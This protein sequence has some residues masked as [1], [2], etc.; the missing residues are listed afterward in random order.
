MYEEYLEDYVYR[1]MAKVASK[2]CRMFV[3]KKTNKANETQALVVKDSTNQSDVKAIENKKDKPNETDKTDSIRKDTEINENINKNEG[4]VAK[5]DA[6]TETEDTVPSDI[7]KSEVTDSENCDTKKQGDDIDEQLN[8]LNFH[9]MMF[10]L[11]MTVT[12]V[13]IPALLT[14]ARNFK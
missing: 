9:M 12:I 7:R 8:N 4:A 5:S 1:L 6:D 14:W 3:S 10:F 11:W 2:M 13:N